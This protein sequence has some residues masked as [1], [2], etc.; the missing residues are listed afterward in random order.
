MKLNTLKSDV[1]LRRPYLTKGYSSAEKKY[2]ELKMGKLKSS[3]IVNGFW[4]ALLITS[5][6]LL[7]FAI[8]SWNEQRKEE[9]RELEILR[10]LAGAI[11]SDLADMWINA[12]DYR[13]SAMSFRYIR[14]VIQSGTYDPDTLNE[15][16]SN[17]VN[18]SFFISNPGAFETLKSRGLELI[19]DDSL[20][21]MISGYYHFS[22]QV[23][24]KFEEHY[25]QNV[26]FFIRPFVLN[27]FDFSQAG[28]LPIDLKKLQEDRTLEGKLGHSQ[29]M[30]STNSETYQNEISA[31]E[32]L[33]D[34]IQNEI[35]RLE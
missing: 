20:R 19:S 33:L 5:S 15:Y 29:A 14:Q 6:V 31:A 24:F 30:A 28:A 9:V 32:K 1:L 17:V 16:L 22:H 26:Y 27:N 8:N 21:E 7:A 3:N 18:P 35:D 4:Q 23:I 34:F 12:E 2:I 25:L 10:S 13:E 11:E